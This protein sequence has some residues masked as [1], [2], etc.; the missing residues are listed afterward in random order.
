ML[1]SC[2]AAQGVRL[3][4]P[5]PSLPSCLVENTAPPKGERVGLYEF[6]PEWIDFVAE[7]WEKD[8]RISAQRVFQCASE[9]AKALREA[10]ETLRLNNRP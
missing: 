7:Y 6:R 10:V 5:E 1:T 8:A 4:L 2:S 3:N 9:T